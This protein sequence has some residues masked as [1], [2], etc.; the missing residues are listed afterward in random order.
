MDAVYFT[1]FAVIF[2]VWVAMILDLPA[3]L[4]SRPSWKRLYL[5]ALNGSQPHSHTVTET[6]TTYQS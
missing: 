5:A 4:Q 6:R 3:R 2:L 1:G